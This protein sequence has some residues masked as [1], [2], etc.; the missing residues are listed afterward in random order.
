MKIQLILLLLTVITTAC[1]DL[2]L[3]ASNHLLQ[4][5]S[6]KNSMI[7]TSPIIVSV[8]ELIAREERIPPLGVPENPNRD[9]GFASVFVRLENPQEKTIKVMIEKIEIRNEYDGKLQFFTFSPQTIELKPLEN[10]EIAFQ[11][12]NKIGY[13]GQ[14]KVKAIVTYRIG[15]QVKVIDSEA[16]S[17]DYS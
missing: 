17:V 2:S 10:S 8:F 13:G 1:S 9:T 5:P 11:L 3:Q 12:S 15:N 4:S 14:E 7:T 6:P 16:V